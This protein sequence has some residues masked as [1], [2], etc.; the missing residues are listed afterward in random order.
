MSVSIADLR[1]NYS[2]SELNEND[3]DSNPFKQFSLWFNQALEVKILEPNAMTLATASPDGKPHARI[4]LLKSFDERGFVFYTNYQSN[5]GKQLSANPHAALV[6]WWAE[7][8]RQVRIEGKVNQ[9]SAQESDAY[10]YSRPIGSQLGA[11]V[12]AQSQVISDR[13]ILET[14]L[15]QLEQKYAN[16]PIPRPPYWGG[17]RLSPESIEFWQGRPNRLHD[18]LL[19][20]LVK[21]ASWTIERLSP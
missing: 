13:Q 17:Y 2:Q 20:R 10:F 15:A 9:V 19:Y 21:P 14:K 18:R 3:V 6:F 8:E 5:K 1:R 12:S 16:Q 7:L 11:W 4:V